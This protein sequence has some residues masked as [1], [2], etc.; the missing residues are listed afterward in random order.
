VLVMVLVLGAL[1]EAHQ[2]FVPGRTPSIGDLLADV[3]GGTLGA[4]IGLC[5]FSRWRF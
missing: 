4:I 2:S 5:V 3:V 1:D